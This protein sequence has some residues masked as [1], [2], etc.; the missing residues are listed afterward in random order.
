MFDW[1][2]QYFIWK[3]PYNAANIRHSNWYGSFWNSSS[4][5]F[6]KY[7]QGLLHL[8]LGNLQ[9]NNYPRLPKEISRDYSWKLLKNQFN[10]F[11]Q[12]FLQ[13]FLQEII[14]EISGKNQHYLEQSLYNFKKELLEKLLK[15][16]INLYE[17]LGWTMEKS[18]TIW[19]ETSCRFFLYQF[20]E[21]HILESREQL[22]LKHY[23]RPMGVARGRQRKEKKWK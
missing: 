6:K 17:F 21:S 2:L 3:V 4:D 12:G 11:V 14:M 18:L 1:F 20:S 22:L 9:G 23:T 5:N 19:H 13:K 16:R 7:K 15:T 8:D 10:F